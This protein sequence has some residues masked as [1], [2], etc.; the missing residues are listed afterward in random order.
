MKD[1]ETIVNIEMI[2]VETEKAKKIVMKEIEIANMMIEEIVGTE[3]EGDQEIKTE[4]KKK[5]IREIQNK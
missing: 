5:K 2:V 4:K 1:I 3:I